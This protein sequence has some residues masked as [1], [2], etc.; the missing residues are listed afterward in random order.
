M[1]ALWHQRAWRSTN[2]MQ[3]AS[4]GLIRA[5]LSSL[6]GSVRLRGV[7]AAGIIGDAQLPAVTGQDLIQ[8]AELALEQALQTD[9]GAQRLVLQHEVLRAHNTLSPA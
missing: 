2:E 1:R 6:D 9:G 3:A 4:S 5:L 7:G 8:L